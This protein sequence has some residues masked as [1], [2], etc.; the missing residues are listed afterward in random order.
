MSAAPKTVSVVI[1][2]YNGARTITALLDSLSAGPD[3]EAEII[4]VNDGSTDGTLALLKKYPVRVI[5]LGRNHGI[6]HARNRGCE[7]ARTPYVAFVDADCVVSPGW[8]A[9]WVRAIRAGQRN[10]P[11]LAAMA[12]RVSPYQY[13]FYDRLAAYIEHWEYQGGP[14]ETRMKLTTSNCI[15]DRKMLQS[16]GGFDEQLAVDEDRE[17]ALR[18]TRNGYVVAYEPQIAV[19]H[20]HAR[21]NL[22]AIM[23]H[24][25]YW[26]A[27]TGLINE[28]RYRDLRKLWFIKY[29]RHPAVYVLIIPGLAAMLTGRIL[30]RIFFQ[31]PAV[32]VMAPWIYLAKLS[33]RWGVFTW[34]LEHK[35][36]EYS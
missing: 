4:V 14:R 6:A 19:R 2:V 25:Y 35:G 27:H 31:D 5:D 3:G 32:L 7:R 8:A 17:L 22:T 10:N 29:I 28:W 33:Y 26:G 30:R 36:R 20:H 34:L 18:L 24:Q 21:T 13:G 16:N 9:A 1:P 23:K 15:C 11:R 12:G